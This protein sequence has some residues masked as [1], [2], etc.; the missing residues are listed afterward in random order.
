MDSDSCLVQHSCTCMEQKRVD[1]HTFGPD[2]SRFFSDQTI[3]VYSLDLLI[4]DL[5]L[6]LIGKD[7]WIAGIVSGRSISRIEA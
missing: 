2:I 1:Q 7:W 4:V 6:L 5:I 3:F